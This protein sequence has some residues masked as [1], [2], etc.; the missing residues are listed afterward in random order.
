MILILHI[1]C[2]FLIYF[3]EFHSC[4][5]IFETILHI[6]CIILHILHIESIFLHIFAY[7]IVYF[8]GLHSAYHDF[9]HIIEYINEYFC[10]LS[11]FFYLNFEYWYAY[12]CIFLCILLHDINACTL[13]ISAYLFCIFP[14]YQA[15]QVATTIGA[16]KL[17]ITCKHIRNHPIWAAPGSAHASSS[18]PRP[19]Y[20]W[21]L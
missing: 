20:A 15:L 4:K 1:L 8:S 11:P 7:F 17:F 10:M 21:T 19:A 6:L 9:M 18:S 5:C 3:C 16:C 13:H 12:L 2:I 14:F